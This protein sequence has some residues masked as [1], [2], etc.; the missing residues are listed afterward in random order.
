MDLDFYFSIS[1]IILGTM[2]VFSR[3][4]SFSVFS[5]IGLLFIIMQIFLSKG[6]VVLSTIFLLATGAVVL[7]III[8]LFMNLDLEKEF[9]QYY[10][11]NVIPMFGMM[12]MGITLGV[13]S[14]IM[15]SSQKIFEKP[16]LGDE[17]QSISLESY[18]HMVP[19]LILGLLGVITLSS[20]LI[21]QKDIKRK[22][23]D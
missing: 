9:Q 23:N 15:F 7:V 18:D 14:L 8:Q 3:Q 13:L 1:L 4:P 17:G 21:K 6:Y 5:L 2:T 20:L 22:D 10:K 11:M 12:V 19:I 16:F